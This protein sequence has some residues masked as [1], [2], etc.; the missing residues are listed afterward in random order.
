MLHVLP[1]KQANYYHKSFYSQ[2]KVMMINRS[3]SNFNLHPMLNSTNETNE[4]DF[5][6]NNQHTLHTAEYFWCG[7]FEILSLYTSYEQKTKTHLT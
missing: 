5:D 6:V 2:T 3:N 4:V 7:R 1:S